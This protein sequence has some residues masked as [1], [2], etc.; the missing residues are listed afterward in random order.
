MKYKIKSVGRAAA[1]STLSK[2]THFAHE[3]NITK[4]VRIGV[5]QYCQSNSEMPRKKQTFQSVLIN[6]AAILNSVVQLT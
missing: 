1:P 4:C 2:V 5:A 6:V 3:S